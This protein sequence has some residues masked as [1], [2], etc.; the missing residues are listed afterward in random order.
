MGIITETL[1]GSLLPRT[2]TT[3]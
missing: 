1:Q 3:H 2:N